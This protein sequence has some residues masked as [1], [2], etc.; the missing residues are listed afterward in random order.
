MNKTCK[1]KPSASR[2]Q[3]C[4]EIAESYDEIPNCKDCSYNVSRYEL[5]QIVTNFWGSYAIVEIN[6]YLE[7]V[8]INRVYDIQEKECNK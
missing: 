5:I 2:C 3:M 1:I 4:N 6:G 7:K 8:S